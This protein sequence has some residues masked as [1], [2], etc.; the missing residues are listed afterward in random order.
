MVRNLDLSSEPL[1]GKVSL[2]VLA[3]KYGCSYRTVAVALAKIGLQSP[4]SST[5]HTGSCKNIDWDNEPLLGNV[6][7]AKLA[8]KHGVRQESV[9]MARKKRGI[10]CFKPPRKPKPEKR[11]NFD[12]TPYLHLMGVISDQR[13]AEMSG[14]TKENV[15]HARRRYGYPAIAG[16]LGGTNKGIDWDNETRL[17]VLPDA[18]LA[19]LLGVCPKTVR[20]AKSARAKNSGDKT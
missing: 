5:N 3:D 12:W 11:V 1:A 17:G 10:P 19:R 6:S 4:F 15:S 18:I 7:D 14:Q 9:E 16:A 20:Q 8:R 2:R 13:I